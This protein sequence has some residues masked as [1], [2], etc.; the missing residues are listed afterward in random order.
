MLEEY[1]KKNFSNNFH[2]YLK[3][4]KSYEVQNN[5]KKN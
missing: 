2:E 1:F 3:N 5:I 4:K